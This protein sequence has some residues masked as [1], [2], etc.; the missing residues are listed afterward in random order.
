MKRIKHNWV[1]AFTL[2]FGLGISQTA[3]A[4]PIFYTVTNTPGTDVWTYEYEL[5]NTTGQLIDFF[6]IV[7]EADSYEL[8]LVGDPGFEE[9]TSFTVPTGWSGDF[10][11]EDDFFDG[12]FQIGFNDFL[13]PIGPIA[14][15]LG[16]A[17]SGFSVT[18]TWTG[19][20]TPGDQA[21]YAYPI[22]PLF[23]PIEFRT[24]SRTPVSVPEPSTL[25]LL[26]LGLGALVLQRRR[27]VR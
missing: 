11:P 21:V 26:G 7:F 16:A 15:E 12:L 4:Q 2:V 22:D 9:V 27:C 14:S 1:L 25:G 10:L 23:D 6:E 13:D 5:A 20:G 24:T 3:L 8:E 17:I 19:F 18:F